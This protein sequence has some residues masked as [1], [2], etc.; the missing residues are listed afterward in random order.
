MRS[1][2]L[3]VLL[4][5]LQEESVPK[6]IEQLGHADPAVRDRAST[7]LSKKG[8][9]ALPALESAAEDADSEVRLRARDILP[10]LL[11]HCA[12]QESVTAA[13]DW[14]LRHQS[15]TGTWSAKAMP[16]GC[17]VDDR[18]NDPHEA[19]L[20]GLALLAL[21][22]SAGDRAGEA[23]DRAAAALQGPIETGSKG[24]YDRALSTFAL[25]ELCARRQAPELK[26]SVRKAVDGLLEARNPGKA[27]RYSPRGGDNDTSVTFWC[28]LALLAARGAGI[29][30]PE[31]A[32][33]GA[34][35]WIDEVTERGGYG[36]IGYTY[37]G[38]GKCGLPGRN[39]QVEWHMTTSAQGHLLRKLLG[40]P[41]GER[42]LLL[43]WNL[44]LCDLPDAGPFKRDFCYWFAG[45]L[46]MREIQG[47]RWER[48]STAAR[49]VLLGLQKPSSDRCA[50]GS[51]DPVDRWS[52]EAGR[53][54]ATAMNLLTLE[55]LA[56]NP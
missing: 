4:P 16:C 45:T 36:R 39:E 47:P 7:A 26:R 19:G 44:L 6:L 55:L 49:P 35:A 43:A 15:K 5:C 21:L 24:L 40:A 41:D 14:L 11:Q 13:V 10:R 25:A 33:Q 46:A 8:M 20:T 9:E 2:V 48:W 23:V 52:D 50:R 51:W 37:R 22:R 3:A 12:I 29:E 28:G 1:L 53:V 27:W 38:W 18:Q 56:P 42:G 17:P 30:I 54:Y 31:A 32:V 34:I